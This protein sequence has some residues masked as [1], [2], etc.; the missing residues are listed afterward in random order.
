VKGSTEFRKV[1]VVQV[2]RRKRRKEFT[3]SKKN[4]TSSRTFPSKKITTFDLRWRMEKKKAP[5]SLSIVHMLE[6]GFY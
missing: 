3:T 1:K 2:E 6:S 5:I 4:V